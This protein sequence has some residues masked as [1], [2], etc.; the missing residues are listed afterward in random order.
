MTTNCE[1]CLSISLKKRPR[2]G[3]ILIAG[4]KLPDTCDA[5]AKFMF[6]PLGGV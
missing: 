5:V 4:K 6:A 3:G 2:S 1:P